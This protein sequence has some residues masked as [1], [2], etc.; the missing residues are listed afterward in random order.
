MATKA[1]TTTNDGVGYQTRSLIR[2]LAILDAFGPDRATLSVKELHELLDLPKP[3]VSR[4]A[5]VLEQCGLLRGAGSGYQL[6]PKTFELGSLFAQQ[7]GLQHAARPA[8][9]RMAREASQTSSLAMLSG[10]L[11]VYL[12]VARPPRP[13]HH[14]T[15]AGSREFAHPTGLGKVLLA[16]LTPDE[17]DRTLG[18][19]PLA[20]MTDNTICDRAELHDELERVRRRGYALD[21]EE[22]AVGLR[23]VAIGLDVPRLGPAAI[24]LSGPAADYS[25]A[26]IKRFLKILRA[27]GQELDR[28]FSEAA[29]SAYPLPGTP[30]TYDPYAEGA[31]A[32]A[33]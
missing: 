1:G 4:L 11:V 31:D 9:E 21:E 7:Y 3:T 27:T 10:R 17:V 14:V 23:C 15:E 30:R 12:V 33:P 24:S 19:E 20:R 6:G 22:F 2:A 28:A 26:G 8:M 18:D 29:Q 16:G 13:I 25:P 5:S 32:P